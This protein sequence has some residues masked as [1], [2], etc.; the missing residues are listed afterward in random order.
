MFEIKIQYLKRFDFG[1]TGQF[2]PKNYNLSPCISFA[3]VLLKQIS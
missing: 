3:Q 1:E 2:K